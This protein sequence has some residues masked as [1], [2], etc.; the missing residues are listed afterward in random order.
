MP[1]DARRQVDEAVAEGRLTE[2]MWSIEQTAEFL[3]VAV[4]TLYQWRSHGTGPRSYRVGGAI[5]YDPV[6]VRTYLLGQAQEP[7]A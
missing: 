5:K 1:E 2:K 7:A 4:G 3:N 6:D